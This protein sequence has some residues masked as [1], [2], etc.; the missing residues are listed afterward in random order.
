MVNCLRVFLICVDIYIMALN[1]K[2]DLSKNTIVYG[3]CSDEDGQGWLNLISEKSVDLIYIDPPF[4][5]NRDYKVVWGNGYEVRSFGDRFKGGIDHY[6]NWMKPKIL[7]SKRVL[8]DT[9]SIFL[10]C[11]WHASHRL[12]CLL[13]EVFGEKSFINEIIWFYP[14]GGGR[15]KSWLNKKHD[16]IFWYAKDKNKF[17]YN[18]KEIALSRN[19][20]QK[21][22]GGYFKTDNKGTYQEVR[23]NGKVYKYYV[24]E[25]K[26]NDDVWFLNIISQRDTTERIGYRT[27]KPEAL[28]KRIV[29]CSTDKNDV[30]LDFFGGGGTTAKV[31]SDLDRRFITGDVSPIAVRVT[32]DRLSDNGYRDYEIKGLP[33]TK[34]EYH[35][36]HKNKFVQ[37]ICDLMGWDRNLKKSLNNTFDGFADEGNIPVFIQN[38]SEKT[39]IPDIKKFLKLLAKHKKGIFVS[40]DFSKEASEYVYSLIQ[41]KITLLAVKEILN[42]LLISDELS[43]KPKKLY[44]ADTKKI[45]W[46]DKSVHGLKQKT[47]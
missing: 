3:N 33:S 10:H 21:T 41:Q 31:C 39:S 1:T 17:K 12:R 29:E 38:Q 30:V 24:D 35:S 47:A 13:D 6:I 22:F 18:W 46:E 37:I 25:P 20:D 26:N 45:S 2:L 36:M 11:D 5:S 27:Q 23:S 14:N 28:I 34:K 32:A 19:Q 44:D 43:K 15:S 4:F 16:T 42:G 7:E 40:W 9:G 8:N